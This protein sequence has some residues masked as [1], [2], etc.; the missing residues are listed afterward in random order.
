MA[1]GL[2]LS[3][4]KRK[5]HGIE[6][7]H[8]FFGKRPHNYKGELLPIYMR[9]TIQGKRL[10]LSCNYFIEP[11]R[12][13]SAAG[14]VKD[15]SEESRTIN[16]HLDL[17]KRKAYDTGMSSPGADHPAGYHAEFADR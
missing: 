13:N 14:K 5:D 7:E 1:I 8:S 15:N 12:W 17:M 3:L 4:F 11:A 16:T 2:I 9:V 6:Y 10:E